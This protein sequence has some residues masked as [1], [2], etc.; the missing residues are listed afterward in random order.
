MTLKNASKR[1]QQQVQL[2]EEQEMHVVSAGS[3]SNDSS[4]KRIDNIHD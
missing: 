4:Q 1:W 2:R 3:Q